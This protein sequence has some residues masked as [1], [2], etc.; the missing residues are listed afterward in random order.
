M[1]LYCHPQWKIN[2]INIVEVTIC[3]LKFVL[4]FKTKEIG[5][6]VSSSFLS[7]EAYNSLTIFATRLESEFYLY[8]L[9]KD[10]ID[11]SFHLDDLREQS[12]SCVTHFIGK[13]VVMLS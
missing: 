13:P 4:N 9:H 7:V 5:N 12:T 3:R 10:V 8:A 11:Q 2:E 6:G 1:D